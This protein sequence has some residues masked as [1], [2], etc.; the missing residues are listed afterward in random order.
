GAAQL[1]DAVSL[2]AFKRHLLEQSAPDKPRR[3]LTIE[4]LMRDTPDKPRQV[5]EYE[6]A[7]HRRRA[8]PRRR[9]DEKLAGVASVDELQQLD[10]VEAFARWLEGRSIRRQ[11]QR[12]AAEA[13]IPQG[14]DV[15]AP[16]PYPQS[17]IRLGVVRDGA[18]LAH[19]LYRHNF[20]VSESPE[21]ATWLA[22]RPA[23]EQELAREISGHLHPSV[24]TCRRQSDETWGL[25]ADHRFFNV[26]SIHVRAG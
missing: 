19:V 17:F 26:G 8:D 25:I 13:R 22:K 7:Q 3:E 11:V 2:R 10:P 5:A 12:L 1:S 16:R 21:M 14:I 18:R 23:D 15:A 6:L 4:D 9:L 20:V 24:V